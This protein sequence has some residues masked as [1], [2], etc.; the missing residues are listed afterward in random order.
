MHV[1]KIRLVENW[2]AVLERKYAA[3]QQ[4]LLIYNIYKHIFV[5]LE[6]WEEVS[7]LVVIRTTMTNIYWAPCAGHYSE[8]FTRIKSVSG[9]AKCWLI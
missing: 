6:L 3:I 1:K 2:K 7:G 9:C 8:N 5:W 4:Y